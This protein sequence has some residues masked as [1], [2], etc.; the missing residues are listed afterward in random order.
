[1]DKFKVGDRVRI[2]ATSF[3]G[4]FYNGKEGIIQSISNDTMLLHYL[5]QFLDG[6]TEIFSKYQLKHTKFTQKAIWKRN[7]K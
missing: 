6:A 7:L 5:V 4:F 3:L 2:K 1:M